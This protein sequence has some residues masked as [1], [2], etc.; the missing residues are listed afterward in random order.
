MPVFLVSRSPLNW[1][2]VFR[3]VNRLF[4]EAATLADEVSS[5]GDHPRSWAGGLPW[6]GPDALDAAGSPRIALSELLLI[7]PI[8]SELPTALRAAVN[9]NEL[10]AQ[11][12]LARSSLALELYH[13]RRAQYP[14]NL[15]SAAKELGEPGVGVATE[16]G[17]RFRYQPL[18]RVGDRID[19]YTLV[20]TPLS[21]GKTGVRRFCTEERGPIR[22]SA[23]EE[24]MLAEEGC[25]APPNE[26]AV[27]ARARPPSARR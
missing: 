16:R 19:S 1:D 26:P 12:R 25:P 18:S 22:W 11:L 2:H 21:W 3:E 8:A 27:R 6:R 5:G 24:G 15:T 10:D 20:A 23:S 14:V 9:E 7:R 17:Y 13:S 4:D